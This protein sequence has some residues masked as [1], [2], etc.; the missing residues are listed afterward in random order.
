MKRI[1]LDTNAYV[2]FK[3]GDV[4][5]LEI[6]RQTPEI[7]VSVVVLGELLAGFAC[8]V[9]TAKNRRELADFL[10][11]PGVRILE[12]GMETAEHYAALFSNLKKKGRPV[13]TNDLWIGATAMEHGLSVFTFDHHFSAME[14]LLVGSR[15]EHFLP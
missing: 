15:L 6:L 2:S 10:R 11:T 13:P 5:T 4:E 12:L 3:R 8:G 14:N 9:H 7:G 1:L